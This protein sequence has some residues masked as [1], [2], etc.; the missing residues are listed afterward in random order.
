MTTTRSVIALILWLVVAFVPA[1]VGSQFMP[2][3]WYR[4]LQKPSWNPPGYLFGPV[5]T[6]LYTLM[7]IAAWLVWKKA[8]FS[9]AGTALTVFLIQLA[10]NGAWTWIFFGQHNIGAALVEIVVLWFLILATIV[11]FWQQSALAGGLLIP[12]LAWVSFATALT[13]AIWRLNS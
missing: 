1:I 3:Q 7:G 5:W 6:L 4:D 2:D 8:G 9:G 10:F 13:F 11:L 12:Y